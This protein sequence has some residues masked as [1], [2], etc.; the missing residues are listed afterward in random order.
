MFSKAF[1][2][3]YAA[4]ASQLKSMGVPVVFAKVDLGTA[5][6]ELIANRYNYSTTPTL[7]WFV[8]GAPSIINLNDGDWANKE[9]ITKMILFNYNFPSSFDIVTLNQ[10]VTMFAIFYFSHLTKLFLCQLHLW[11]FNA[12]LRIQTQHFFQ[13]FD[14]FVNVNSKY[15]LVFFYVPGCC[16]DSAPEFASAFTQIEAFGPNPPVLF[17]QVDFGQNRQLASRF[18]VNSTTLIWFVGGQPQPYAG[19][20]LMSDDIVFWVISA[21]DT[22]TTTLNEQVR[23]P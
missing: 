19:L 22:I 20:S 1:S 11:L 9:F 13:N 6:G 3:Q 15:A 8:N 2:P 16:S 17:A 4:S 7:I 5:G 21:I 23:I 10:T 18:N 14:Q 12:H